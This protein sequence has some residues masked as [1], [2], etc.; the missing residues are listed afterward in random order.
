[1]TSSDHIEFWPWGRVS[2]LA[3]SA[4]LLVL[5]VGGVALLRLAADW[6][7]ARWEGAFILVAVLLSLVPLGLLVLEKVADSQ[8]SVSF[9]GL[10]LEFGAAAQAAA[11]AVTRSTTSIPRN[12]TQ[13][14]ADV[15]DSGHVEVLTV[16]A[17]ASRA[18]VVV[19]DLE[20]GHAWWDTRLLLLCAGA[21]LQGR[22]RAV[23]FVGTV[24]TVARRFVGWARPADVVAQI[25]KAS[26]DLRFAYETARA[27]VRRAE[28]TFPE[29]APPQVYPSVAPALPVGAGLG[30]SGIPVVA[31]QELF[32]RHG[33]FMLP[34]PPAMAFTRALG[35]VV[36]PLEESGD[37][38]HL[39]VARLCELLTPVLH[40]GSIDHAASDDEW[41][42]AV[43]DL[44]SD[45]LA[46]TDA[47]VYRGLAPQG[48][49]TRTLLKALVRDRL[50]T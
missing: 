29:H 20:D 27:S 34:Q 2:A 38:A 37:V 31:D 18:E 22:P 48:E 14:G 35:R 17:D 47:G 5:L 21:Q 3:T 41:V 7:D 50:E 33:E 9:R 49:L 46:V 44:D 10:S 13:E 1:M 36:H 39:T 12:V 4:G 42:G 25:L 40:T 11:A 6:P 30:P 26:L 8:G 15:G 23:V 43:V 32:D 24:D 45:Y 16:L 19:V 28:L